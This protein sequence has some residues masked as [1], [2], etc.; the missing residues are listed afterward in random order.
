MVRACNTCTAAALR[1]DSALPSEAAACTATSARAFASARSCQGRCRF[2]RGDY[3]AA[4]RE[5]R[6][7]E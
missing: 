2:I 5:F 7:A 1:T 6:A 3:R 4:E